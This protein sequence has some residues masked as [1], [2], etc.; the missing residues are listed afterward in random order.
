MNYRA[1]LLFPTKRSITTE[2]TVIT[3]YGIGLRV[4]FKDQKKIFMPHFEQL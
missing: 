4:G 2:Q 1:L 3:I